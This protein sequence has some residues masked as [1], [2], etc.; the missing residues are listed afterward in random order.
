MFLII[1]FNLLIDNHHRAQ[2]SVT[3]VDIAI[4]IGIMR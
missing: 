4:I 3:F 2:S 1:I